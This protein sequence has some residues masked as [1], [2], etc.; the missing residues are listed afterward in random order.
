MADVIGVFSMTVQETLPEVT[1]LVNAGMED[2]KNMEVFVHKIKG[3]SAGVGACKVVKAADDLLEAMETR[4]QIRGMHAL[5]AMTNEFH[6]VRE[7]LDNLAE[8]D[9]RMFAIKAQV[10]LMMER[11]RSISSRNS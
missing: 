1:R 10:L 3:S 4:N 9:A 7:K 5:H 2:V 11:S 6:I 8:L